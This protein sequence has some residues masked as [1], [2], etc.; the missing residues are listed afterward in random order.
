MIISWAEP[1]WDDY[2]YRRQTDKKILKRINT[3]IKAM[4]REPFKGL[5][6]PEPLK[7]NW[8]GYWSRRIDRGHRLV[9]K[10]VDGAIVVVQCGIITNN[11][12]GANRHDC[13]AKIG[14]IMNGK[15]LDYI[16][17]LSSLIGLIITAVVTLFA[18]LEGNYGTEPSV[19]IFGLAFISLAFAV[20]NIY[21]FKRSDTLSRNNAALQPSI[22]ILNGELERLKLSCDNDKYIF[23]EIADI[24][25]SIQDQLRDRIYEL[26]NE[27]SAIVSEEDLADF[28]RIDHERTNEMFYLFLVDNIKRIFDLLTSDKC[29]VCIKMLDEGNHESEIMVRTFMRDSG[30]YRERKS[31]DKAI[32][33]YPYH[34]NSAFKTILA[35]DTPNSYYV[36]DDLSKER[37]YIN[38]N[39]NWNQYYNATLVC[40]IRIEILE[41]EESENYKYSVLG[42]ICVDNQKGGLN[43][44]T[45]IQLLAGISDSLYNHFLLFNELQNSRYELLPSR[46][47]ADVGE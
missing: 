20:V 30:S 29:S 19:V 8:S 15:V 3:L 17:G 44:R 25:H 36:S 27:R 46:E 4:T 42:F 39:P 47:I 16:F 2:R 21:L 12:G 9:Y 35:P 5:G 34:E 45:A 33:E 13:Q 22:D 26:Y 37:T 43:N 14:D 7:H 24:G 38:M 28:E 32:Y 6:D 40:P 31:S 41:E 1:A 18:I 23:A 11:R 10:V